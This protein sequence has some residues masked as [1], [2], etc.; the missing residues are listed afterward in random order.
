MITYNKNETQEIN[1]LNI[2]N[3][4]I[5]QKGIGCLFLGFLIVV[6]LINVTILVLGYF[7]ERRRGGGELQKITFI[8]FYIHKGILSEI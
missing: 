4:Q 7:Y 8:Q 3:V 6:S 2:I 5:D 1:L